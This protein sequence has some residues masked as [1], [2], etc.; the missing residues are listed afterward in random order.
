VQQPWLYEAAKGWCNRIRAR[1]GGGM[2][3]KKGWG[4]GGRQAGKTGGEVPSSGTDLR[5][6]EGAWQATVRF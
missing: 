6:Q 1:E 5:T 4:Q 3:G 2:Q